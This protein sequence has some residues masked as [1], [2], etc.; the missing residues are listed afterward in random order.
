MENRKSFACYTGRPHL[1]VL[2][3]IKMF[4]E[5]KILNIYFHCKSLLQRVSPPCS[6]TPNTASS[7]SAT[8]TRSSAST[9]TSRGPRAWWRSSRGC[10]EWTVMRIQTISIT[11]SRSYSSWACFLMITLPWPSASLRG[12]GKYEQ[13]PV[14]R[15]L[16]GQAAE[17]EDVWTTIKHKGRYYYQLQPLL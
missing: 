14:Q 3:L 6:I 11:R 5:S 15:D 4:H 16:Q 8:T 1:D 13:F 17:I 2:L 9:T 12:T 10:W 7:S